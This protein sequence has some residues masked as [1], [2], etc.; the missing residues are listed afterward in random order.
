MQ[1]AVD[2]IIEEEA[3]RESHSLAQDFYCDNAIYD[4][5]WSGVFERHRILAGH[6]SQ[7][8]NIGENFLFDVGRKSISISRED[9]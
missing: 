7:I 1:D 5:D 9:A 4:V 6:V 8:K 2:S 3:Q